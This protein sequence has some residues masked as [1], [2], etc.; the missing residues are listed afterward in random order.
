M[1]AHQTNDRGKPTLKHWNGGG[2][3]GVYVHGIPRARDGRVHTTEKPIALM[4]DLVDHFTDPGELVID[5]FAG[6]GTT[7]VACVRRGRRFLGCELDA[8]VAAIASERLAAESSGISLAA[9]RG[10]QAPLFGAS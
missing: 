4:L 1:V 8:N 9:A 5:P 3:R 10:G 2:H 7:G 6:S